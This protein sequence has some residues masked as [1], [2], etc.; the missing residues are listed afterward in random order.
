MA[1]P[2]TRDGARATGAATVD[3]GWLQTLLK[4]SAVAVIGASDDLTRP[5]GRIVAALRRFGFAGEIYPVNPRRERIQGLPAFPSVAAINAPIDVAL[6]VVS[7]DQ[8]L[9]AVEQA[10]AGGARVVMVGSA[11]FAE[12]GGEGEVRQR[13][14]VARARELGVRLLGPNTNGVILSRSGLAGTFTPAL[15]RDDVTLTDGPVA[16]VSQSGALGGA[17]FATA[18]STHLHVGALL[19]VG[20]AADVTFEE[21]LCE[22][23]RRSPGTI[24]LAYMEGIADGPGL[25]G[26]ARAA[27]ETGGILILLKVGTSDAGAAAAAAHT[28]NLA[29]EDRVFDGVMRQLGAVRV[30]SLSQLLDAGRVASAYGSD[31]GPRLTIASMSGGA[32]I[33]LADLARASGL[34]LAQWSPAWQ[35]R[36]DA[37]LPGY[38]SRRNPI[39][40]A[41]R[42]FFD[43]EVLRAVLETMDEN[44]ESDVTILAVANFDSRHEPICQALIDAAGELHKPLFV[45]W[46]GGQGPAKRMLERGGVP[47]FAEPEQCIAAIAPL[48]ARPGLSAVESVFEPAVEGHAA[49]PTSERAWTSPAA[50]GVLPAA[51]ARELLARFDLALAPTVSLGSPSATAVRTVPLPAVVKLDSPRLLHKSDVGAVRAGL[52]SQQA[53]EE[54]VAAV[55]ELGLRLGLDDAEII[56]Q[57]QVP[58]GTELLLGMKDDAVFGPVITFGIGGTFAEAFDDVV[59]RLPTLD[60]EGVQDMLGSLHHQ[61]LLSGFRGA[62]PVAAD[63]ITPYVLNFARLVR[64][65]GHLLEAIDLNPVI[66][67]PDGAVV[68]VDALIVARTAEG[69]THAG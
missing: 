64:N 18:Q 1:E 63:I 13:E 44:P 69:G 41:G 24:L 33:I 40:T 42:P 43:M 56:A 38:L 46:I 3:Q 67:T 39:D 29:V 9:D 5:G 15:E 17:L 35:R 36:L 8:V 10:A 28:A 27:H 58:A 51:A 50:S 59:V 16:I 62:P 52:E 4:P 19:N 2:G 32:G 20:N 21:T 47:C 54:A 7:A 14:L 30:R 6:V 25:I 31:I 61:E 60:A 37:Y 45:V 49:A 57:Q 23:F 26:A 53:V 22:V 12:M 34:E 65:V 48:A 68:A 66:V 11:G 55:R